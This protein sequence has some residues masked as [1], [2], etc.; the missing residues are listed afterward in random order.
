MALHVAHDH[1]SEEDGIISFLTLPIDMWARQLI[2][3]ANF[4]CQSVLQAQGP[5]L[6]AN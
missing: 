1:H 3:G 6:Q 2:Y 5:L 4:E